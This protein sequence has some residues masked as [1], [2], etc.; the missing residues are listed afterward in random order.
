MPQL[1]PRRLHRLTHRVIATVVAVSLLSMPV[2]YRGGAETAHAHT[3]FQLWV[4]ARSGSF[5]HHGADHA[6]TRIETGTGGAHLTMGHMPDADQ[7]PDAAAVSAG[8][9]GAK[10]ER[11]ARAARQPAR[12]C[13]AGWQPGAAG[14]DEDAPT[15]SSAFTLDVRGPILVLSGV[16]H[17]VL[18]E[19]FSSTGHHAR[20]LDGVVSSPTPPPPRQAASLL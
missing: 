3:I 12:I 10:P 16:P 1:S 9:H 14:V 8:D 5:T 17:L 15:M 11:D 7:G 18:A 19:S 20:R 6:A 2:T 4:D 13:S